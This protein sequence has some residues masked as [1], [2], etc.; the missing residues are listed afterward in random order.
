MTACCQSWAA[1]RVPYID[2][3]SLQQVFF[4]TSSPGDFSSA[5]RA[6]NTSSRHGACRYAREISCTMMHCVV[7]PDTAL[8]N[9]SFNDSS[10]GVPAKRS[11]LR[12]VFAQTSLPSNLMFFHVCVGFVHMR[13]PMQTDAPN[14][15]IWTLPPCARKLAIVSPLL[16]IWG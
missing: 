6:T 15:W 1:G 4:S 16:A 12:S 3:R 7:D 5:Q 10:G 13:M 9:T 8:L 11:S 2:F 14:Q